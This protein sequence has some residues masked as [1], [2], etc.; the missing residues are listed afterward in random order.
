MRAVKGNPQIAD[1]ITPENLKRMKELEVLIA[2]VKGTPQAKP[3][4]DEYRHLSSP[5]ANVKAYSYKSQ[6]G[7]S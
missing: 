6:L 5:E 4:V 2:K 3:L 1:K 7:L